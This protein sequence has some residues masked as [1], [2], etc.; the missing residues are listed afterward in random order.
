MTIPQATGESTPAESGQRTPGQPLALTPDSIDE[1]A[2]PAPPSMGPAGWPLSESS[3]P[4]SA[5]VGLVASSVDRAPGAAAVPRETFG[6]EELS[7]VLS[8][9]DVGPIEAMQEF[10]KGSRRAPKILIKATDGLFLLKRRATGRDDP[11]RVDYAHGVQTH[12]VQQQFPVPKLIETR[13]SRRTMLRLGGRT[14]ELFEFIPGT[15]YDAS[16]PATTEGGRTLALFHKLVAAHDAEPPDALTHG[17]HGAKQVS[18][19][20]RHIADH[21]KPDEGAPDHPEHKEVCAALSEAYDSAADSVNALGLPNW[22]AQVAHGDWHP[23]NTLFR[24]SRV[25]AVIDFDSV[26]REPRALDVAN[27]A[28]QFSI[29]MNGHDVSS[30]PE[31]LDE[32]R[33]KRFCRGYD[34][35]EGCILSTPEV[36]AL[37]DLMIEALVVEAVAP[38]A[39]TGKFAGLD[40]A[41]F[42]AMIRRK[43]DWI[44]RSRERLVELVST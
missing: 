36:R 9:Y 8:H 26:R 10:R 3:I 29:T 19:S 30:W 23:G 4:L 17:Y 24:G 6:L 39:A 7:I 5:S 1:S 18:E 13:S 40:G 16:L 11:L 44:R 2:V 38:I 28:L 33:F 15:K 12:L 37:P 21:W 42:L 41:A 43:A 20:L 27:G 32:S 35:V 34:A 22:P 31:Y 14:Y 25:V